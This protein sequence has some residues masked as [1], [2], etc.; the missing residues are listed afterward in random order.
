MRVNQ[1]K[2]FI[3][4]NGKWSKD[5]PVRFL[6]DGDAVHIKIHGSKI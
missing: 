3:R 2:L 5:Q 4:L 6:F 1:L